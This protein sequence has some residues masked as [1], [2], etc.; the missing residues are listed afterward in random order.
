MSKHIWFFYSFSYSA[1]VVNPRFLAQ[2]LF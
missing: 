2:L 1:V